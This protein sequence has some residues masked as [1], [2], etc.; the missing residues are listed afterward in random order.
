LKRNKRTHPS[1][2]LEENEENI[3]LTDLKE[4]NPSQSKSTVH[5]N[6]IKSKKG[7]LG[8]I[9]STALLLISLPPKAQ[10]HKII[11]LELKIFNPCYT[12]KISNL[13]YK[14]TE[15]CED[16]FLSSVIR[17]IN[18][19]C[20][21][22]EEILIYKRSIYKTHQSILIDNLMTVK[23]LTLVNFNFTINSNLYH[24]NYPNMIVTFRILKMSISEIGHNWNRKKVDFKI[25]DSLPINI[26]LPN[27]FNVE[28]YEPFYCYFDI[29]FK[30]LILQIREKNSENFF[31]KNLKLGKAEYLT[32]FIISFLI[33]SLVF[34]I[35][36]IIKNIKRINILKEAVVFYR[37]RIELQE[38][39]LPPY[40]DLVTSE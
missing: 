40:P 16:N 27:D 18:D 32:I 1:A 8:L 37:A 7:K 38:F 14:D 12:D 17:P 10:A 5:N 11:A 34:S 9:V 2:P 6:K 20:K 13:T 15:W 30:I 22:S 36:Q 23:S 26:T 4:Q 3:S 28:D 35:S 21:S 33:F 39:D 25:F 29:Q 24:L 31:H 19:F